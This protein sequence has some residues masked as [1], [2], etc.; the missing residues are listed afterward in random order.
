VEVGEETRTGIKFKVAVKQVE[1]PKE[2][3]MKK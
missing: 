1:A 3:S 2:W